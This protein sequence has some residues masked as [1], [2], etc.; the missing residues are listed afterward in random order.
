MR[1]VITLEGQGGELDRRV[2]ATEAEIQTATEDLV[3]ACM[4][5]PG[6][7]IRIIDTQPEKE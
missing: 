7:M 3:S 4:L 2:V 6:D 1:Y 5:A